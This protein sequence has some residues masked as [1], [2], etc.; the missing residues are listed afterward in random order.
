VEPE[1]GLELGRVEVLT[2]GRVLLAGREA[3]EEF[4]LAEVVR[5]VAGLAAGRLFIIR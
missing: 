2:E 1:A 3:V 4:G 5:L